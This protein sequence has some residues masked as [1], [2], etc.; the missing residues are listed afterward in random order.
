MKNMA[1]ISDTQIKDIADIL[2]KFP[3]EDF[4]WTANENK[5]PKFCKDK[6]HFT[7]G[8][9]EYDKNLILK[10]GIS[11]SFEE[12]DKAQRKELVKWIIKDWGGINTYNE[13]KIIK[14]FDLEE[15][16]IRE[17]NLTNSISSR[18]KVFSFHYPNKY[19]IC[20]SRNIFTLNWLLFFTCEKSSNEIHLFKILPSR[21]TIL[22]KYNLTT[23]INLLCNKRY[24]EEYTKYYDFCDVIKRLTKELENNYIYETEMLLFSLSVSDENRGIFKYIKEHMKDRI[25]NLI[26]SS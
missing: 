8:K 24:N 4:N 26:K 11:R 2:E 6:I 15:N 5:L 17:I 10:E 22:P 23:V 13:D 1:K 16:A 19:V 25:N 9:N 14:D 18:S 3:K 20:D 7:D 21:N 12:A